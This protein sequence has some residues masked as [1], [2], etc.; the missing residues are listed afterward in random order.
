MVQLLYKICESDLTTDDL[1]EA[2]TEI[3]DGPGPSR[4][5]LRS[6]QN[7]NET[8]VFE[9]ATQMLQEPDICVNQPIK[10][11][12]SN[13]I[14]QSSQ[15][16]N[17]PEWSIAARLP[18][19]E[20]EAFEKEQAQQKAVD[21]KRSK[22]AKKFKFLFETS[23]D[24]DIGDDDDDDGEDDLEFDIGIARKQMV[25]VPAKAVANKQKGMNRHDDDDDDSDDGDKEVGVSKPAS[26]KPEKQKTILD[27]I[28]I[29][30]KVKMRRVSVKVSRTEV[31]RFQE[32]EAKKKT[33]KLADTNATTKSAKPNATKDDTPERKST[34]HRKP[35]L[36]EETVVESRQSKRTKLAS[37]PEEPPK[38]TKQ[39]E[40]SK[41][42]A[43][44]KFKDI[45]ANSSSTKKS[46]TSENNQIVSISLRF[47]VTF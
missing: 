16:A 27:G 32:N 25:T 35:E 4:E 10:R 24:E 43:A 33:S 22:R 30:G 36:I 9:M 11:M 15:P 6:I 40:A 47:Y 19:H 5:V 2:E 8:D 39:R 23:S 20:I 12:A 41:R 28:E 31:K 14:T 26:S 38:E 46:N 34:R 7:P 44:T 18:S 29:P 13:V 37:V 3:F 42:K 45:E 1:F 17:T 21:K